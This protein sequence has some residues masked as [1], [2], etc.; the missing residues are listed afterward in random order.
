[1]VEVIY[2][3]KDEMDL[4]QLS[5]FLEGIREKLA[6]VMDTFI[7]ELQSSSKGV[8][9]PNVQ[10][11]IALRR[12]NWLKPF[13]VEKIESFKKKI[14]KSRNTDISSCSTLVIQQCTD[15]AKRLDWASWPILLDLLH[16]NPNLVDDKCI[17]VRSKFRDEVT[18][19]ICYGVSSSLFCPCHEAIWCDVTA[20]L[21]HELCFSIAR[22]RWD[23][24]KV[25]TSSRLS[26]ILVQKAIEASK[27]IQNPDN[28]DALKFD[29]AVWKR[30]SLKGGNELSKQSRGTKCLLTMASDCSNPENKPPA[31]IILTDDS[32]D[33]G[34]RNIFEMIHTPWYLSRQIIFVVDTFAKK[35]L[36]KD[37]TAYSFGALCKEVGVSSELASEFLKRD[38]RLDVESSL[39]YGKDFKAIY[40]K[41][42]KLNGSIDRTIKT[43]KTGSKSMPVR[44]LLFWNIIVT[45]LKMLGWKIALGY[46]E[47]DWYLLPPGVI[48]GKGFKPRID[49]FDS[50]PLVIKCLKT[51]LRYCNLPEIKKILVEYHLCQTK[52]EEMKAGKDKFIKNSLTSEIVDFLKK[53]VMGE[54]SP[55]TRHHVKDIV[56]N[57]SKL[58]LMLEKIGSRVVVKEVRNQDYT[59][60]I[61][62]GDVL[63]SVGDDCVRNWSLKDVV[64]HLA[65]SDRPVNV[66][67]EYD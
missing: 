67:F 12:L 59:D 42:N 27:A 51:D 40:S 10:Q 64:T 25:K 60:Q 47:S 30:Y 29:T 58:G 50:A 53:S 3:V 66:K 56:F 32:S 8:H 28:L 52:Y 13:F 44:K 2:E 19:D 20:N 57:K 7:R 23:Y 22:N 54:V 36:A 48:R 55:Q 1:M 46:R 49:F 24:K 65:N 61:H 18:E 17:N 41:G 14:E 43:R 33:M 35:Y 9:V 6:K 38:I 31:P 11:M 45:E 4:Y 62:P 37:E 21:I 34:Q 5:E 26:E 63:I 16:K 39:F 15:N